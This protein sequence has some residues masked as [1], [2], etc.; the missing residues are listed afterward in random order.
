MEYDKRVDLVGLRLLA[1]GV[2]DS[3]WFAIIITIALVL[4]LGVGLSGAEVLVFDVKAG[5]TP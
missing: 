5:I 2:R 1:R 3:T 4:T